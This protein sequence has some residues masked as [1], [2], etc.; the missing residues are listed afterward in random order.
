MSAT[1]RPSVIRAAARLAGLPTERVARVANA[2]ANLGHGHEL[3]QLLGDL[4]SHPLLEQSVLAWV[5]AW[6]A[7][8]GI[9]LPKPHR[10]R[11][12]RMPTAIIQLED[13]DQ[14]RET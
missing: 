1:T 3:E 8:A 14:D 12:K 5:R 6:A 7:V 4:G 9:D 10:P 11:S 2:A 13:E